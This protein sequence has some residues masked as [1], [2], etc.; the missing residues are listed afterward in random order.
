MYNK[1]VITHFISTLNTKCSL[2]LI[3]SAFLPIDQQQ[4]SLKCV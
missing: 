4:M 3:L 2:V 1:C